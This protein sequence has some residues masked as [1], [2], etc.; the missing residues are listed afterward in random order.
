M[1]IFIE[2]QHFL[3]NVSTLEENNVNF[4]ARFNKNHY[5]CTQLIT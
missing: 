5:I 1:M 3:Q 2:K 4:F